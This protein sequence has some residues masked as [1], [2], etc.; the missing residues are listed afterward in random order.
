MATRPRAVAQEPDFEN[1]VDEFEQDDATE[2]SDGG[3]YGGK[4]EELASTALEEMAAEARSAAERADLALQRAEK[5]AES[6][7]KWGDR[8][9]GDNAGEKAKLLEKVNSG[10][11]RVE[12]MKR[13]AELNA[14]D[15]EDAAQLGA[16]RAVNSA[17][18]AA[19]T[20]WRRAESEAGVI[21]RCSDALRRL[22]LGQGLPGR[23][24]RP[25]AA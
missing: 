4:S 3:G 17:E 13:I 7:R 24:G 10:L 19:N 11:R 21:G 12:R 15:A 16:T 9:N 5:N 8:G 18:K 2:E 23:R 1:E 6:A 20:A 14:E 25:K 22:A